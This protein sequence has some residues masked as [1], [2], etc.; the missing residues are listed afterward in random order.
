MSETDSPLVGPAV[1]AAARAREASPHPHI[2]YHIKAPADFAYDPMKVREAIYNNKAF[3]AIIINGNASSLLREA[4]ILGNSSYDPKGTCQTVYVEARDQVAIDSYIVPELNAFQNHV[5]SAFAEIWVPEV[6]E[7]LTNG[8]ALSTLPSQALSPAI[9]FTTINIRPFGPSQVLPAVTVGLIYLIIIAFFSYTFFLPT[10]TLF[11]IQCSPGSN[12]YHR[13]LYFGQLVSWKYISTFIAYAFMS[14]SYSFVSLAFQIP[15]SSQ[16]YSHVE[17]P[18]PEMS[19][20]GYGHAS[21]VIYW[22][23]NYLGMCALGFACENVAMVVG[24][25][26]TAIWLIFWVISNVCTAFYPLELAAGVYRYGLFFPLYNVVKATRIVLFDLTHEHM[27]RHVGILVAW[28]AVNTM[29]FPLAARVFRWKTCQ[30]VAER[31]LNVELERL[32]KPA[33]DLE[34]AASTVSDGN[35]CEG[36]PEVRADLALQPSNI[37]KD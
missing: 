9:G 3:S 18:P 21:F 4:V 7:L 27:G 11:T 33:L 2:T 22:A 34:K 20:N 15:F 26:F 5:S 8:T 37:D 24:Q 25:P 29:L 35:N 28:W 23:I 36:R 16:P 12:G 13:K 17:P 1:V 10:H 32:Q 14:L 31:A 30:K 6:L 19:V